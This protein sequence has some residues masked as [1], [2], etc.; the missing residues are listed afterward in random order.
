MKSNVNTKTL[1]SIEEKY[2]E[3]CKAAM[4]KCYTKTKGFAETVVPIKNFDP[5]NDNH[6]FI[7]SVAKC[8]SGVLGVQVAIDADFWSRRKL[9]K[10]IKLKG[11]KIL[12]FKKEYANYAFSPEDVLEE[13]APLVAEL[14]PNEYCDFGDIYHLFYEV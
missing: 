5:S 6:M 8:L 7:L 10:N 12:P 14:F 2:N 1:L 4:I 3:L 11:C 9:N 13:L